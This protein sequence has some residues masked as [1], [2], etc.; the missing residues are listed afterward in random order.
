MG[1][2]NNNWDR[3]ITRRLAVFCVLPGKYGP[4]LRH[5][6]AK[7]NH[8]P[9]AGCTTHNFSICTCCA[10][11]DT[12]LGMGKS[13]YKCGQTG[14]GRAACRFDYMSGVNDFE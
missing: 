8:F 13:R 6:D 7:R 10:S 12:E 14:M 1:P 11:N 9:L 2:L 5:D 3:S 4:T